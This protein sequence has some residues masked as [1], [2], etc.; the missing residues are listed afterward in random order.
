MNTRGPV[1][2]VGCGLAFR[3]QGGPAGA[4]N[5]VGAPPR[6][7]SRT[8]TTRGFADQ[9]PSGAYSPGE[10]AHT[11]RDPPSCGPWAA[12]PPGARPGDPR[13]D[14]SA[15]AGAA[16]GAGRLSRGMS[17]TLAPRLA[18]TARMGGRRTAS[19]TAPRQRLPSCSVPRTAPPPGGAWSFDGRARDMERGPSRVGCPTPE[20]PPPGGAP[21][22]AAG[23]GSAA[24]SRW[25]ARAPGPVGAPPTPAA[26]P[27]GA[28]RQPMGARRPAAGL[29]RR[30]DAVAAQAQAQAQRT[31]GPRSACRDRSRTPGG[32]ERM[33]L[34]EGSTDRAPLGARVTSCPR[35]LRPAPRRGPGRA[36]VQAAGTPA[37]PGAPVQPTSGLRPGAPAPP[38]PVRKRPAGHPARRPRSM[39][40]TA[41]A[42]ASPRSLLPPARGRPPLPPAPGDAPAV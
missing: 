36:G 35:S 18:P 5:G 27:G 26:H 23:P 17:G 1:T 4:Q 7:L 10:G 24:T 29:R 41:D 19:R 9:A 11:G 30:R 22:M 3:P 38:A 37:R 40:R 12:G 16:V 20:P 6:R 2:P 33:P 34:D 25:A 14:P 13:P 31:R 28:G 8:G 21:A 42:A 15:A 32:L 39:T